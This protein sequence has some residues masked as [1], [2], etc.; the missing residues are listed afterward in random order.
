[1]RDMGVDRKMAEGDRER[2]TD[3]TVETVETGRGV[4]S[5]TEREVP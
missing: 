3:K 2:Q 4:L 1:M 5:I